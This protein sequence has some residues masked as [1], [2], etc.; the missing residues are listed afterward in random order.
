MSIS[1]SKFDTAMHGGGYR[2]ILFI[3]FGMSSCTVADFV[4]K[5]SSTLLKENRELMNCLQDP[6]WIFTSIFREKINLS[7]KEKY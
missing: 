2:P 7:K 1:F 3:I 4:R 5:M 6:A